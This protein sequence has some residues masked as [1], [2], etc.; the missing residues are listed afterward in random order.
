MPISKLHITIQDKDDSLTWSGQLQHEAALSKAE[1]MLEEDSA[2][3]DRFLKESDENVQQA[4]SGADVEMKLK[5][6]KVCARTHNAHHSQQMT[7]FTSVSS[8]NGFLAKHGLQVS[9]LSNEW[10]CKIS[11]AVRYIAYMISCHT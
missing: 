5:Q 6:G 9:I 10:M 11:T 3:F 8:F 4:M 2:A 7:S 1:V